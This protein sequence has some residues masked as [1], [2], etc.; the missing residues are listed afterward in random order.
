MKNILMIVHSLKFK[1]GGITGVM[2]NRTHIFNELLGYNSKF[3]T[4]DS[5]TDYEEL[6]LVF[7][8]SGRMH[9]DSKIINLYDFYREKNTLNKV[10]PLEKAQNSKDEFIVQSQFYESKKFLRYFTFEGKLVKTEYFTTEGSLHKEE[11]Y[12]SSFGVSQINYYKNN[13]RIKSIRCEQGSVVE[14]KFY[15]DDGFCFF[16]RF[17]RLGDSEKE[18]LFLFDRLSK[19]AIGFNSRNK[20]YAYFI[21]ELCTNDKKEDNIVI[22]DGPGSV[23]KIMSMDPTKALRFLTI[24]TNHY[25]APYKYG[26][27]IKKDIFSTIDNAR[28][29]DGI[30]VLTEQQRNDIVK[31]FGYP[32]KYFVIPNTVNCSK[33]PCKKIIRNKKIINVVSRYA[34]SKQL[35]HIVLSINL[36]KESYNLDSSK[37]HVSLFGI[38]TQE[39]YLQSLVLKYELQHIISINSYATDIDEVFHKSDIT[40]M[41]S[42]Y[43]GFGLTIIEAMSNKTPVI[44]YDINYG[45]RDIITDGK[46]GFLVKTGDIKGLS[47][48]IYKVLFE[49]YNQL[50]EISNNAYI[51]VKD[52]F[53][54]QVAAKLWK[55]LLEEK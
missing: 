55:Q 54:H 13:I 28:N 12:D 11:F 42:V 48:M 33:N 26:A 47:K 52:K 40:L 29:V 50:S 24:H 38:G 2:L 31:Q 19:K 36:L 37:L 35:D 1:Q 14:E 39:E 5:E 18:H 51:K 9:K 22:N 32:E 10:F 3:L 17:N 41:S 34:S 53:S 6:E 25:Q 15:T 16:S 8:E 23:S 45:P 20:L 49:D 44:S 30:I 4:F 27:P 46:D 43:E 21:E 7:K